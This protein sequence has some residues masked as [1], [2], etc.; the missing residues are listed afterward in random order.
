MKSIYGTHGGVPRIPV[1]IAQS[2]GA[3]HR[4]LGS[5][6]VKFQTHELIELYGAVVSS[7]LFSP[8]F[9][10]LISYCIQLLLEKGPARANASA[11]ARAG[12]PNLKHD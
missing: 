5:G 4:H 12:K 7:H 9:I 10:V 6:G 1:F 8:F 3:N 2:K 11:R